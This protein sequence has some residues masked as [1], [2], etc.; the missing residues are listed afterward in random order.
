MNFR[1]TATRMDS[2]ARSSAVKVI[3]Q[4]VCAPKST[5]TAKYTRMAGVAN[6]IS[7]ASEVKMEANTPGKSNSASHNRV[8]YT[9]LLR[10]NNPKAFLTRS[11]LRA[12]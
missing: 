11:A 2:L 4:A 8:E 12:P 7:E 10:S 1:V 5:S 3:W 9:K 6:A